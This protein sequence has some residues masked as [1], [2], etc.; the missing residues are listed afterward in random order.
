MTN[1]RQFAPRPGTKLALDVAANARFLLALAAS[2]SKPHVR[3]QALEAFLKHGPH[4]QHVRQAI[5]TQSETETALESLAAVAAR[6]K[7]QE[8]P[9]ADT[10]K[11]PENRVIQFKAKRES[12]G[13]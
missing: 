5:G 1:I 10:A 2:Y 7:R 9:V 4:A 11:Q 13:D 6:I 8:K 3:L 12:P